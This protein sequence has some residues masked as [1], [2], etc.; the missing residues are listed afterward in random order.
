MTAWM[1]NYRVG[2]RICAGFGFVLVLLGILAVFG[3]RISAGGAARSDD[4][5]HFTGQVQDIL[6]IE[7]NVA[8][9]RRSFRAFAY[10]KDAVSWRQAVDTVAILKTSLE[11]ARATHRQ[12]SRRQTIAHMQQLI[13]DYGQS[14]NTVR[15]LENARETTREGLRAAGAAAVAKVDHLGEVLA[16]RN[17]SG[18]ILAVSRLQIS[19]LTARLRVAT[20]IITPNPANG[21]AARKQFAQFNKDAA[22]FASQ[23]HG[24]DT[25]AMV[26]EV[27]T[28]TQQYLDSFEASDQAFHAADQLVN[29][30]MPKTADEIARVANGLSAD[31][32][33]DLARLSADNVASNRAAERTILVVALIALGLG[34]LSA[35]LIAQGI[36]RPVVGMTDT[37]SRLAE[38]DVAVT[39]PALDNRDEI[40]AMA[41]AVQVFR[42]NAVDKA[43]ME[44]EAEAAR[45]A[46]AEAAAAESRRRIAIVEEVAA[47]AHAA[48]GGDLARRIGLAG[49]DGFLL[50]L[51][52]GVNTLVALTELA[53]TDV[54]TVLAALAEGDLTRRI[55]GDYAGLF[56][57]V[58]GDV[59]RTA[60][61][62][63]QVM[64]DINAAATR[65]AGA[66]AEVAAGSQD[67]SE[68][69]E[70]QA[71]ALEETAASMEEL[72]A[73]VKQ[74]AANA[75]QAN[76][77]AAGA[78]N[79]A[80]SGGQVVADAVA[81]MGRIE[82]S[83]RKIGDIVGMIDEIAFQTNLLALNAAVEAARAGD[84]GRSFAVVAQEVRNLAQR[85]AQASKE[86]KGLIAQSAGEVQTGA[87]L[88]KKAGLTLD[89]ILGSVAQ[90]AGIV[91][92][93]AAASQEQ[94][95]GIDQVNAAVTQMDEMTQQ[96]AALV[97]ESA[98]A[99][100]ALED[101]A[102]ELDRL[103]AFFRTDETVAVRQLAG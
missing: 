101:Q 7:A 73:T 4:Y 57:Q 14:M 17:E 65:I 95:G 42:Q 23:M 84:A 94:A 102:K 3:W 40:G 53:L 2:T 66:S 56:G 74:T 97:E 90:V 8:E 11:A 88:V 20:Y 39:V 46:A 25:E 10:T 85:S 43:R 59:N 12:E 31:L 83:S 76:Q 49:K 77:L 19:L 99:A 96:N 24:A 68:R 28:L 35:W 18:L 22:A 34:S 89:E 44:A 60:D 37:M 71:S 33:A 93:I 13:G 80:S 48:G 1:A 9:L 78:R 62:L 79:V 98:A 51:C 16:A 58:K 47:V 50:S 27:M 82:E 91:G 100:S 32:A 75:Q 29:G 87:G 86:I 36:T 63:R 6:R 69:S 41:K 15:E 54:A 52:E 72:A 64:G 70:Q 81:A 45:Q 103:I 38:G 55:T 61:R 92:E 30:S 26:Q 21:A 67:L 5:A